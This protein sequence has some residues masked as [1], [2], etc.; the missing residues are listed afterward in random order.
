M[1]RP[2]L[3]AIT[4]Q[5]STAKKSLLNSTSIEQKLIK[6]GKDRATA[7]NK[8]RQDIINQKLK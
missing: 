7:R 8:A 3:G 5:I 4:L 6:L 1:F 2:Q